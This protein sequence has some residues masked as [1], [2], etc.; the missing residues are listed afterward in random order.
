MASAFISHSSPDD[1]YVQEFVQLV[2]SLGFD[3]VFNDSHSIRPDEYFWPKIEE[4]IQ[5]CDAFVVILS[6]ASVQSYWVDKEVQF[7]RAKGKPIIPVRIDNC[8]LPAS[9]DGRDV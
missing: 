3:E 8:K 6:Q 1:R 9:F 4:G 2:G 5:K 7:A